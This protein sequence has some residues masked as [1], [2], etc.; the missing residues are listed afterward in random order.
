LHPHA[1][2]SWLTRER[3]VAYAT[4]LAIAEMAL[5]AFCVAG[6]HGLIVPMQNQPSTDFASFH[7]AGAL[8]DAGAP[9]L[10]YD[11]A[12]HHA[13][14]QLSSGI[15]TGYNYFYYPPV[16]LLVCAPLAWLPYLPAFLLLQAVGAM[17]CYFA[18]N[19]IRRDLPMAVFLAF[20]GV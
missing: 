13:A 16:F 20:P 15:A 8:A 1:R 3:I 14:E 6:A 7:A 4:L 17:A 9:W 5:F 11:R 2:T 18:V 12:A 19:L 10:A